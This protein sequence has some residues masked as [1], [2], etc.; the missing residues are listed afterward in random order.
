LPQDYPTPTVLHE[1]LVRTS[2]DVDALSE[3]EL[4]EMGVSREHAESYMAFLREL[5]EA[6][7]SP[8]WSAGDDVAS[9][10]HW[11]ERYEERAARGDHG[12]E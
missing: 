12:Y 3:A 6:A 1:A 5:G 9:F 10:E 7:S 2:G 8:Y 11:R 4:E